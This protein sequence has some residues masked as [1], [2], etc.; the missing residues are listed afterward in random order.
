MTLSKREKILLSI[1]CG[2]VVLWG[3]YYFMLKPQLMK[4]EE[5]KSKKANYQGKVEE[6]KNNIA[7][8][9]TL[10]KEF[11]ILNTK[12]IS[13]TQ[14]WFPSM[15]QE[16]IILNL[17]D[18]LRESG[19]QVSEI[20]FSKPKLEGLEETS[21]PKEEK[22]DL[23][24]QLIDVYH[25][26]KTLNP[27]SE[28]ETSDRKKN[29]FENIHN[30]LNT[31]KGKEEGSS[32][33]DYHFEAEQMRASIGYRGDYQDIVHFLKSVESFDKKII[34]KNLSM[35]KNEDESLSGRIDLD[36]YVIPKILSEDL[37]DKEY[38]SWNIRNPYGKDNPFTPF[39]GYTAP[40]LGNHYDFI[41]MVRPVT[42][43]LSTVILG[44]FMDLTGK[45]YI[46]GDNPNFEEVEFQ[47]L[48]EDGKYYFKYKTQYES[49]P[50]DYKNHMVA[51]QPSGTQV[52]LKIMSTPRKGDK[53]NSGVHLSAINKSN[54]ILN[55]EIAND[56]KRMPR[57]EIKNKAG[58]I[59][60]K[61]I[62]EE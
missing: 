33:E 62:M 59:A 6:V 22:E 28:G 37:Q 18:M 16:K 58:N 2:V 51:F 36:F 7:S 41:M 56:D 27:S 25:G 30:L 34:I 26:E 39:H 60:V 54:L 29:L 45:S 17:D 49:Y 40:A 48:Q 11:K 24:K 10:D 31:A 1:L 35:V 42:P 47:I 20:T 8:G 44:K 57:V 21:Q 52:T 61:Q 38:F 32:Q 12:I 53:D 23:L 43:D 4:I 5:L 14:R 50:V 13:M 3:Y 46:Y 9:S 19:L 15:I 55:I